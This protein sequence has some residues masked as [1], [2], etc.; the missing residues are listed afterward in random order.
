MLL[1]KSNMSLPITEREAED[2]EKKKGRR[3]QK[4]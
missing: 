1:F 3:T 2:Y 4:N